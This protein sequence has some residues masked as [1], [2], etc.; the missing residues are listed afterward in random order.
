MSSSRGSSRSMNMSSSNYSSSSMSSRSLTGR[1]TF[2][3]IGVVRGGGGGRYGSDGMSVTRLTRL[4]RSLG[5]CFNS[6]D[7]N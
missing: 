1:R 2:R 7:R 5:R 3:V 4:Y 6:T